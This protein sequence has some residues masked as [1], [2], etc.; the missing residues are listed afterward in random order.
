MSLFAIK[1]VRRTY[2]RV[3]DE[4]HLKPNKFSQYVTNRCL[5]NE[6]EYLLPNKR[7]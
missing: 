4:E 2:I 1:I 7:M 6:Y 5:I 3:E